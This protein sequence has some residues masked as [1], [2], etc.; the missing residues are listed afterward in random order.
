MMKKTIVGAAMPRSP[1]K[2]EHKMEKIR[3]AARFVARA[4][5]HNG[6]MIFAQIGMLRAIQFSDGFSWAKKRPG[7][8]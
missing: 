7:A 3:V 2:S 8:R 5:E 1:S 6:P 4:A